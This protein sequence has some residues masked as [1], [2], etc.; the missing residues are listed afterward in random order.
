MKTSEL[1]KELKQ[2][3]EITQ[4]ATYLAVYNDRQETVCVVGLKYM[5]KITTDYLGFE[6]LS[7]LEQVALFNTLYAY[8]I[9][10]FDQRKDEPKFKVKIFPGDLRDDTDWF[11]SNDTCAGID[12]GDEAKV[13]TPSSYQEYCDAHPDWLAFLPDYSSENTDSFIPVEDGELDE[14]N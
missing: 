10:S 4:S 12:T 7:P 9:T 11:L 13:F 3:G 6:H 1:V 14:G 2:Y 8:A 5:F